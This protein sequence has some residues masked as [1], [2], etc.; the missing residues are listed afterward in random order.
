M[1]AL[2]QLT[3]RALAILVVCQVGQ[4]GAQQFGCHL[5]A[6]VGRTALPR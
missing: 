1:N 6:P 3:F 4:R 5:G 2:H